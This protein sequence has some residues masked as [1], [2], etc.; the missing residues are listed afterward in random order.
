MVLEGAALCK[1]GASMKRCEEQVVVAWG[2]HRILFNATRDQEQ[3]SEFENWDFKVSSIGFEMVIDS[4]LNLRM[5]D[6]WT[7][8]SAR[9]VQMS[10]TFEWSFGILQ[11]HGCMSLQTRSRGSK[12]AACWVG[13]LG[14]DSTTSQSLRKDSSLRSCQACRDASNP[15]HPRRQTVVQTLCDL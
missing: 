13:P 14:L 2:P 7:L 15:R 4:H 11:L 9:D 3:E 5:G 6:L 10:S 1:S 12:P 8:R